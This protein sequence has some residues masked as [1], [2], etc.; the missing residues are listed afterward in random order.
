MQNTEQE[1]S[2]ELSKGRPHHHKGCS[3][4]FLL[5]PFTHGARAAEGIPEVFC[6]SWGALWEADAAELKPQELRHLWV[7][8][9]PK[10]PPH[11]EH[12]GGSHHKTTVPA[13]LQRAPS[14]LPCSVTAPAE[15]K[16][17]RLRGLGLR[18]QLPSA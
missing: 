2:K 15:H 1:H 11:L 10:Q 4:P 16:D 9:N 6:I 18:Q 7:F 14:T 13:R 17:S 8:A 12:G 3:A 5:S